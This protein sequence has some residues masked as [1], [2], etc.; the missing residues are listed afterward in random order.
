MY[1]ELYTE[2]TLK[3]FD[4]HENEYFLVEDNYGKII[5]KF[6]YQNGKLRKVK[7]GIIDNQYVGQIKPRNLQQQ[8]AVD[9][10]QDDISKV[11]LIRGVFGSGKDLL[12]LGEA[13]TQLER[14]KFDKIIF[15]R[16]NI[17]VKELPDIGALPGTADE[18]LAWT[19]GPLYDKVGGEQ[20]LQTMITDGKLEAPPLLYIRGR[21]FEHCLVY[22]TEGQN[23]TQELTKLI[24]SRVG[25]GS[26]LWINGDSK[27]TDKK[28]YDT[29]NGL[30]HMVDRLKGNPLFAY[31]WLPITERGPVSNLANLL[32]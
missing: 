17:T 24:I 7:Y 13:L 14:G 23:M 16:S 30:T 27:Q 3:G 25:D 18:K 8:L 26:E 12:M 11:K 20:G 31:M 29:N 21:S 19:L 28:I 22:V 4:L 32:D 15:L 1:Q 5:D 2:H 9:M 6:C 10:L